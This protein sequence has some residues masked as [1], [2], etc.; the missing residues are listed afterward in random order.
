MRNISEDDEIYWRILL[1]NE[2]VDDNY[3][4]CHV[5][6]LHRDFCISMNIFAI[7]WCTLFSIKIYKTTKRVLHLLFHQDDFFLTTWWIISRKSLCTTPLYLLFPFQSHKVYYWIFFL[8]SIYKVTPV[9]FCSISQSVLL[10]PLSFPH[11]HVFN[12]GLL[13]I[14]LLLF[15]VRLSAFYRPEREGW[16]SR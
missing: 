2:K 7:F 16:V 9:R 1:N 5:I 15:L 8:F 6:L 13:L 10:D 4:L 12:E 14:S 11:L 3:E